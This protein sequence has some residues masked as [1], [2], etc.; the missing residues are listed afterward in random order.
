MVKKTEIIALCYFFNK[1]FTKP[2]KSAIIMQEKRE[3]KEKMTVIIEQVLTLFIF[4]VVGFLLAK[5]KIIKGSHAPIASKLLVYVFLPA[6]IIKT[7]A[8]NCTPAYISENYSIIL[9]SFVVLLVIASFSHL[10]ARVF[11]KEKSEYGIYEYSLAIPNFAYMGYAFVG[12]IFGEAGLMDAMMFSMPMS[13][14]TY[15]IGYCILSGKQFSFKSFLNPTMIA[16]VIGTILGLTGAGD[17]IPPVLYGVLD[18]SS[19]CM[20]P[21]SMLLV[22]IVLADYKIPVLLRDFRIYIITALRLIII[23]VALGVAL[24][25][26]GA[27]EATV[28]AAVMLYSMPCGLN[29]VVFV[30]NA[31]GNCEIGAGLAL[32]SSVFACVSIPFISYLFGIAV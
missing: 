32:L 2:L 1:L 19:A 28:C 11:T 22:G 18:S 29:T 5:T 16:L 10:G 15:T 25:A 24:T 21:V 20:A 3:R 7:F 8:K 26:F 9:V 30:K 12:A 23:P 13:V 31:G 6:N 4:V 14:Y 17:I 27:S